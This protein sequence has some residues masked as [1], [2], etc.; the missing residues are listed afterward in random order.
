MTPRALAALAVA[1]AALA[2]A[3]CGSSAAPP[4]GD[5]LACRHFVQQGQKLKSEA[6]P[7]LTDLALAGGW[8]AEDAQLAVT[9]ALKAAFTQD[10]SAISDLMGSLGDTAAQQAAITKRGDNA[11]AKVKSICTRDGVKIP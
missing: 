1:A 9:P 11:S 3:A 5:V 10:S 8:V 6:T 4:A 7:S 2:L